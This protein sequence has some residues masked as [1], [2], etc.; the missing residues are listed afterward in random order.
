M[1]QSIAADVAI[2]YLCT[3]AA[4]QVN[5][6]H[7]HLRNLE[8]KHSLP[9][10]FNPIQSVTHAYTQLQNAKTETVKVSNLLR[11]ANAIASYSLFPFL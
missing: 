5:S 3:G 1:R 9:Y 2:T 8:D 6:W 10:T 11:N 7:R 4:V